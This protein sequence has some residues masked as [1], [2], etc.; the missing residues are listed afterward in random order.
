M[1]LK[2][3]IISLL[4]VAAVLPLLAVFISLAFYASSQ[5]ESL[6][7]MKLNAVYGTSRG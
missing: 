7:D 5:R 4:V 3:R 1:R 2:P 6:V